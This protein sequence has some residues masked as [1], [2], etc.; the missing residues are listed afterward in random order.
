MG[1]IHLFKKM[2]FYIGKRKVGSK[3]LPLII[4]EIGINHNG[5]LKEAMR[6]ADTAINSGA[7]V[8]K[9]Q[10]HIV[11]DEMIGEAKKI[12]PGNSNNNIFEIMEN[13]S[14]SEEDEYLLMRHIQKKG[15]NIYI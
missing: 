14:L 7:E 6:I 3:N 8:I 1:D 9:H 11:D 15:K 4:A 10:T 13:S 5:S 12:K 2:S